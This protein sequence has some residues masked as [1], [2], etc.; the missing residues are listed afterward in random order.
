[1]IAAHLE[2]QAA[3]IGAGLLAS[4]LHTHPS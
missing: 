3:L 2:P 1:V 4:R